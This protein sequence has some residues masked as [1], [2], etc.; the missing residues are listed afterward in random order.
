MESIKQIKHNK[1][2]NTAIDT[3]NKPVVTGWQRK[4][5]ELE[6]QIKGIKRYKLLV[7]K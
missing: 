4:L 3:M 2:G 5:G 1:T 7:I 6:K